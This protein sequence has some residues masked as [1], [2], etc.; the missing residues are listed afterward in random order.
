[1]NDREPIG[2]AL[3]G[4]R[5]AAGLSVRQVA[6]RLGKQ[7]DTVANFERLS[8]N[9]R[10]ST[11]ETYLDAVEADLNDLAEGV[12]MASPSTESRDRALVDTLVRANEK[13]E[14]DCNE[15]E[16]ERAHLAQ[17]ML[18]LYEE[19]TDDEGHEIAKTMEHLKDLLGKNA[20]RA[21]SRLKPLGG[22]FR[23]KGRAVGRSSAKKKTA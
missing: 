17:M 6:D 18:D 4:L 1:M 13:L 14:E 10:W 3:R 20:A 8:A 2:H 11:L 12:G 7:P 22:A 21:T 16:Q 23:V 9:P 5:K 19:R 15:I